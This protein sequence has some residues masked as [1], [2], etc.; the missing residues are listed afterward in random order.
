MNKYRKELPETGQFVLVWDYDGKVWSDTFKWC[1]S[2][3]LHY[4][5]YSDGW[6]QAVEDMDVGWLVL[7]E[8]EAGGCR[9]IDVIVFDESIDRKSALIDKT[10]NSELSDHQNYGH[11]PY[12][13]LRQIMTGKSFDEAHLPDGVAAYPSAIP[14]PTAGLK[15]ET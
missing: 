10:I 13:L 6:G 1:D 7:H 11:H 4:A 14:Y 5:G 2:H 15:H 9:L 8:D 12:E 3:L